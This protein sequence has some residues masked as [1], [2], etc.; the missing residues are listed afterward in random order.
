MAKAT[1]AKYPTVAIS[2]THT[3]DVGTIARTVTGAERCLGPAS[4]SPSIT[5]TI[6]VMAVIE[7]VVPRPKWS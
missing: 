6:M 5:N 7:K 2:Q 1:L 3:Y 4:D